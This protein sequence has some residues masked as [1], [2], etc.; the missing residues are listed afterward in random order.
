MFRVR[1]EYD[2]EVF[3]G[4]TLDEAYNA[5]CNTFEDEADIPPPDHCIF[6]KMIDV[7]FETVLVEKV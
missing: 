3:E 5:L 7:K 1:C 6:W 4:D 2:F